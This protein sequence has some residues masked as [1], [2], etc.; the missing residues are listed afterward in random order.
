MSN[1]YR[2]LVQSVALYSAETWTLIQENRRKLR[3]LEMAVFRR[4]CGVTKIDHK[5]NVEMMNI[6]KAD[7][8]IVEVIRMHRLTYF[9]H[10]SRM[11]PDKYPHILLHGH[12]DESRP[13]GRQRKLWKD[14]IRED[15]S[16]LEMTL[17]DATVSA[18]HSQRWR[19]LVRR[20]DCKCTRICSSP[21]HYVKSCE[22]GALVNRHT[23]RRQSNS[24]RRAPTLQLAEN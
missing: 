9:G 4:I 11:Q 3:V 15:C 16:N 20:L 22:T 2:T 21:E 6:L 17:A 12:I 8:D 7:T 23:Q 10:I 24:F 18:Q 1:A 19:I 13:K 14:N 5:K